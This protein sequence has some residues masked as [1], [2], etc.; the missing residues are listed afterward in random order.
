MAK[1]WAT[2]GFDGMDDDTLRRLYENSLRVAARA[3]SK[4]TNQAIALLP[5]I[6]AELK[7]RL[8]TRPLPTKT[9]RRKP[10]SENGRVER[11]YA[12]AI[13]DL[14]LSLNTRFDLSPETAKRLS[15]DF[16]SFTPRE[17]LGRNGD[18]LVGGARMAGKVAIDRYTAYRLRDQTILLSVI[19]EK[20]DPLEKL[21]FIVSAPSTLLKNP[22]PLTEIRTTANDEASLRNGESGELFNSFETAAE[23]YESLISQLA[24]GR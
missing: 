9:E 16:R 24:P 4:L 14:V 20:A 15:G 1:D 7:R 22:Q 23:F 11:H 18:T 12:D 19:L 2:D 13:L 21:K 6:E 17:A 8:E 3:K 5:I 10:R